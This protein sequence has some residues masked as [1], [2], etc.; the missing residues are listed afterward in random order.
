[1]LS[2]AQIFVS[3][4]Y[5]L[6][7]LTTPKSKPKNF[8]FSLEQATKKASCFLCTSS[9]YHKTNPNPISTHGSLITPFILPNQDISNLPAAAGDVELFRRAI[10]ASAVRT[11][12][13]G[14]GDGVR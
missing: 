4:C 2:A 5:H 10:R 8:K 13:G 7:Q 6:A 14:A 3:S 12:A 11:V 9:Y 1:M